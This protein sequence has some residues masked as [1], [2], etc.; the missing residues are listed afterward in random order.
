MPETRSDEE[1]VDDIR[2]YACRAMDLELPLPLRAYSFSFDRDAQTIW[3]KA[4][5]DRELDE[6]ERENLSCAETVLYSDEILSWVD[7]KK[8]TT[9]H[10]QVSVVPAGRPLD[11]LPRGIAF[12]RVGEPVPDGYAGALPH[13]DAIVPRAGG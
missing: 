1:L 5:V 6:D 8:G 10:T 2:W 11:P 4:E 7:R 12:L 9:I 13:P 3:I